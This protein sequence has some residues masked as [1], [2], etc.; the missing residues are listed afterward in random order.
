MSLNAFLLVHN[1]C[2]DSEK[3]L[4]L[5]NDKVARAGLYT[6]TALPYNGMDLKHLAK[7]LSVGHYG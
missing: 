1:Q 2:P 3:A 5:A 7:L 6:M 4:K